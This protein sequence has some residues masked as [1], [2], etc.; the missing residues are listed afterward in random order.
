[1]EYTKELAL[2]NGNTIYYKEINGTCYETAIFLQNENRLKEYPVTDK[3]FNVLE[4]YRQNKRR[5]R[6]WYC[7]EDG[8]AWNEEY[9]VTGTIG[10]STGEKYK[11]P[12]LI[13]N[14][15]SFGGPE[16]NV[17]VIGR[18]DDIEARTTVYKRD[19]FYIPSFTTEYKDKTENGSKYNFYVYADGEHVASFTTEAKATRWID[20]MTGKR[21]GK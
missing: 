17:G 1:M 19:N 21:Y 18:I 3:L 14:R 6:F 10:R 2:T 11:I 4:R 12:L 9:E 16:L 8:K 15:K 7:S 13:N 5:V 20:F